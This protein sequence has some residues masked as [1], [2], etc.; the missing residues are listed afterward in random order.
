[1]R[2]QQEDREERFMSVDVDKM[3]PWVR[4]YYIRKHKQISAQSAKASSP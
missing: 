1:M 4:D 3:L 2:N